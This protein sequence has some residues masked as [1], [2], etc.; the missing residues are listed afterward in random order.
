MPV[1]FIKVTPGNTAWVRITDDTR[2]MGE[3]L[4]A[5]EV[6]ELSEEEAHLLVMAHKAVFCDKPAPAVKPAKK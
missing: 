2:C 3:H 5:G 6:M 4:A 1:E